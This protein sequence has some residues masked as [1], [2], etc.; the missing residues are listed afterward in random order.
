MPVRVYS[1]T[2]VV[3]AA[4]KRFAELYK[5]GDRVIISFSGGKDSGVCL[6]LAI[7]TARKFNRLPVDVVMRDEEIMYPGTFE[8]AERVA[9]RPEVNFHWLIANQPV[10][11]V[12]NRVEPYFWV[13]DPT[14]SPEDWVR[15]PPDYAIHI[16]D[17]NIQNIVTRERFPTPE[18][19]R[20]YNVM[21]LRASESTRRM[22]SI[23]SAKGFIAGPNNKGVFSARPIYD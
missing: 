23:H 12:F 20:L 17:L 15:Q 9:K 10:V 6:E 7:E 22:L 11:N 1:T 18:G 3:D 4:L 16:T 5:D 2:N 14:L 13:F 19:K 8:Y 21:G